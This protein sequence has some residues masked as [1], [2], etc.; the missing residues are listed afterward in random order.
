MWGI[1]VP[2]SNHLDIA[3]GHDFVILSINAT[4]NVINEVILK[5]HA[6]SIPLNSIRVLPS[7]P[8]HPYLPP[9]LGA[10]GFHPST[11]PL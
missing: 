2:F 4:S 3:S 10:G 6:I 9:P 7:T 1:I 8:F 11:H 5:L